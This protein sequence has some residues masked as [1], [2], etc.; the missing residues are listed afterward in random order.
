MTQR[1]CQFMTAAIACALNCCKEIAQNLWKGTQLCSCNSM[2]IC[3]CQCRFCLNIS[4][5]C[6]V[7]DS[8]LD[9]TSLRK[10]ASEATPSN[11][12]TRRV[13]SSSEGSLAALFYPPLPH[14]KSGQAGMPATPEDQLRRTGSNDQHF[15]VGAP[16]GES[17]MT[18][19]QF[20]T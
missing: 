11:A 10:S 4:L 9:Q 18:I 3:R 2:P 17:M 13:S 20:D 16:H 14:E 19:C 1:I 12:D 7:Q 5:A 15:L 8:L 6:N